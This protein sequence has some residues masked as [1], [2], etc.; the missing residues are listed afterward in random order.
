[1]ACYTNIMK[2]FLLAISLLIL[3]SPV[4]ISRP[5][6]AAAYSVM[7]KQAY[8]NNYTRQTSLRPLPYWRTQSNF[9]TRNRMNFH[10]NNFYNS[11]NNY[12]PYMLKYRGY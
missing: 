6:N 8:R 9:A 10:N 5:I 12:N 4:A 3:L 1:M 2:K 7:Q 11:I